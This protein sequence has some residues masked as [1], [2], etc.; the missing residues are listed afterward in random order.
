MVACVQSDARTIVAG[1]AHGPRSGACASTRSQVGAHG[2]ADQRRRLGARRAR[3]RTSSADQLSAIGSRRAQA[4]HAREAAQGGAEQDGAAYRREVHRR[5][6]SG[7]AAALKW[8]SYDA[9]VTPL[10]KLVVASS[11]SIKKKA[12]KSVKTERP[13]E[14]PVHPTLAKILAA[15]KLGGWQRMMGRAPRPDDLLVPSRLGKNRS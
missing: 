11:Y 8:S 13:R 10:G 6:R 5:A 1:V 2:Q 12:E 15:W 3:G 4:R 14:V 9:T 7:E